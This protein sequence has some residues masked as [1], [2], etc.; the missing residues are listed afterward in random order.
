MAENEVQADAEQPLRRFELDQSNDYSQYLLHSKSEILAVFRSLIQKGSLITVHFDHGNAFLLTSMLA[1]TP[2]NT[3]FI[4]DVGSDD[5]MNRKALSAKKLILTTVLDK[6]KIQFRLESLSAAQN[7]GRAAFLATIPE[8]LLR[9][10]RREYF[11]LATPIA[12]PIN[13]IAVARRSDGSAQIIETPLLDISGGGV[14]LMATPDLA[15]QLN[16]GDLLEDCKII[17]ADEGLL[18]TTLLVRNMFDV[19]T[20]TGAQYVRVGCEFVDLSSPRLSMVQRYITR[21][22]RERKARLS[23]MA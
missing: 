22:E 10:Q 5:E 11:R 13:L 1:L 16:R 9:L 4:L 2:D 15:A 14:G 12:T 20:R 7:G 17:L 21:I 8:S 3:K 19:T 6:V 23:G 18:V